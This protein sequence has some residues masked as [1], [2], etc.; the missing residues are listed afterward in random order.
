MKKIMV[1]VAMLM[2][3]SAYCAE[4]TLGDLPDILQKLRGCTEKKST[5]SSTTV[6]VIPKEDL[7]VAI[8]GD[9][10]LTLFRHR[11]SADSIYATGNTVSELLR[12]FASKLNSDRAENK[13]MLDAAAQYLPSQ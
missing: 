8:H 3:G 1:I 10:S 11:R 5:F 6:C 2:S 7:W 13:V 9:G 12:D 4:P